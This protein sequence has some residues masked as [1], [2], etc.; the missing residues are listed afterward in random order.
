MHCVIYSEVIR[1]FA[2]KRFFAWQ[3]NLVIIF[4]SLLFILP[5]VGLALP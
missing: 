2:E 5:N 3:W 4:L 1:S